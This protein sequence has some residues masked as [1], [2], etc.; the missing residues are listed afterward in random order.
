LT[1]GSIV[2]VASDAIAADGTKAVGL[3]GTTGT[4][5]SRLYADALEARGVATIEPQ[6]DDQRLVMDVIA[7]AKAGDCGPADAHALAAVSREPADHGAEQIVAACTEIVLALGDCDI[8]LPTVGPARLLA[9][10]V[11]EIF[12]A[13]I[14]DSR[15]PLALPSGPGNQSDLLADSDG[16]GTGGV[17]RTRRPARIL[18][19]PEHRCVM[20]RR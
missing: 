13:A 7:G 9:H 2:E 20:V 8:S 10:R 6:V 14:G 1:A 16:A 18:T 3:L 4:V 11:V 12:T 5:R 17:D 15:R 19:Y